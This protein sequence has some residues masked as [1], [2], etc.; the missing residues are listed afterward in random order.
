[1]VTKWCCLFCTRYFQKEFLLHFL[2]QTKGN[3]SVFIAIRLFS[4]CF[5]AITKLNSQV[6]DCPLPPSLLQMGKNNP[7]K[8][9]QEERYRRLAFPAKNS[10]KDDTITNL[11]KVATLS[12]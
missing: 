11:E 5:K 6:T 9:C 4:S 1:M 2:L 10:R 3:L 7:G 8:L 12:K